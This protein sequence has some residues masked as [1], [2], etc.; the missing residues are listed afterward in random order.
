MNVNNSE[1]GAVRL[2]SPSSPFF[3]QLA[4]IDYRI[5]I[6]LERVKRRNMSL[7]RD[8]ST[9]LR[10]HHTFLD[11]S[12]QEGTAAAELSAH[13]SHAVTAH[14]ESCPALSLERKT[15]PC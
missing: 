14:W 12:R 1:D 11:V 6:L 9:H 15:A 8:E 10:L 3:Q 5:T 7:S 4:I 13:H 2:L